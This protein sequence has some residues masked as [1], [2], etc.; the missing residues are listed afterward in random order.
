MRRL[1]IITCLSLS[2][3]LLAACSGG[4][5]IGTSGAITGSSS[6]GSSSGGSSS[7]G[8]TIV[9]ASLTALS[10]ATTIPVDGSQAATITVLARNSSNE[11]ISGVDVSF[12]AST[13]GGLA[14]SGTGITNSSGAVTATL[15]AVDATVGT[16]ITVTATAGGLTATVKVQV[17]T[18][19]TAATTAVASLGLSTSSATILTDGTTTATIT[20]LALDAGNNVLAGV[21]VAFTTT[22]NVA[23]TAGALAASGATTGA[24]GTVT[25]VL[26]TGGN[27]AVRTITVTGTTASLSSQ[28]QIGVIKPTSPTVPVYSMGYGTGTAFV[29]N[30]ICLGQNPPCTLSGNLSAGGATS[31]YLTIV[32]Q[33]G[34]LYNAGAVT[35]TFNS[36]CLAN[37]QAQIIPAG[38]STPSATITTTT[39][40]I[41]ATYVAKGCSGADTISASGTVSGQS[42][43]ATGSL[44]VAAA[45]VGS[46]Q[47]VSASNYTIGLKGTGLNE[48]STVIFKVTDAT[49]GAEANIP[50]SFT[51][52]TNLGGLSLSPTT[53]TSASDGTVQTVIS[54]GTVHTVVRVTASIAAN[55]ANGTPALST[56]SSQLTV[57]TGLPASGSFSIAVGAASNSPSAKFQC[58]NVEGWGINLI[59]VP[60]TVQL[61][62]RYNNPVPDG[63]SVA[64]Q[65]DGGSVGGNCTTGTAFGGGPGYCS[66]TWTSANPRPGLNPLTTPPSIDLTYGYPSGYTPLLAAGRATILASTI[67]EESFTDDNGSG[68]YQ[69]GDP[70]ADLGDPFEDDNEQAGYQLG[71]PFVDFYHTGVYAPPSGSFIGITC[72][73]ITTGSTCTSATL[74]IGTSHLMIMSTSNAATPK[75]LAYGFGGSGSNLTIANNSAGTIVLQIADE[76]GNAMAAGTTVSWGSF[77]NSSAGVTITPTSSPEVVGCDSELVNPANGNEYYEASFTPNPAE[78]GSG[79]VIVTITSPSG[80]QTL[81]PINVDVTPPAPIVTF[82]ASPDPIT[83]GNTSTLTWSSTYATS[84][85]ASGA[86]TGSEPTSGTFMTPTLTTTSTY[87]LACTGA[88]GTSAPQSVI[89]TVN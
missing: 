39:G 31:M 1:S 38:S 45:T 87:M 19:S 88:G 76:N 24:D 32:D 44:T 54:S 68:F 14:V 11:L 30:A 74:A 12:S 21:P 56:Q 61:A 49:G 75:V 69:A 50:V 85:T 40:T 16:P 23:G 26:S 78:S 6:G 71:D 28:V 59:T 80:S 29:A 48:T 62:D 13:G 36:T 81:F 25:A 2:L 41:N 15:T 34:T 72:T 82:S 73:G 7:G 37:G 27:S 58:P 3:A 63:T 51:L 65:T 89:V 70:F 20:A 83:S 57:T 5:G 33:T 86:W 84:C 79:T 42:I 18:S 17:V 60:I 46:I 35:V 47:F 22:S 64:F 52:D 77:S 66:V 43:G 4:A 55:P 10:S 9:P 53:A 8:K 67:G